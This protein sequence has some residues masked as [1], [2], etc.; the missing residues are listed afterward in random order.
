MLGTVDHSQIVAALEALAAK[1]GRRMLEVVRGMDEH[2]PDYR[3][4]LGEFAGLLQR[5]AIVQ[6]VPDWEAAEDEDIDLFK[7]L[8][9]SMTPEDTQLYYQIALLGRRDLELAPDPRAGFEM[10]LLRML[11]FHREAGAAAEVRAP[12]V[13][14]SR[15]RPVAV[16]VASAPESAPAAAPRATA[17]P[18]AAVASD[19][20][21]IVTQLNLQG[22]VSQLAAHC[23]LIGR[24]AGRVQLKLDADGEPFRRPALEEKL[25][26]A[27][28]AYFGEPVKLDFEVAKVVAESPARRKQAEVEDR[29][30]VARQTI[31]SDP[32]VRAMQDMFG[33]T[34]QPESVKPVG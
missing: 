24:Q 13:A 6:A 30:Q 4:A 9:S 23:T 2:V 25:T 32:N 28:T 7:R 14:P 31:E 16:G 22:P 3:E 21:G 26:A 19:W 5:I 15:P 8:A 34:V 33:A 11:A 18:A 1:D 29:Q 27:L 17:S 12:A 20:S 10:A